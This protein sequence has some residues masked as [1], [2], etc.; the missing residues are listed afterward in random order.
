MIL[1][2]CCKI[3]IGLDILRRR[4]DGFHDLESVMVPV[5]GLYDVIE[6]TRIE[7]SGVEFSVEGIAVDCDADNNLCVKAFRLMQS[8]YS[9]GGVRIKLSKRIPFGAGLGGGSSDATTVLLGLNR[10]FDLGLSLGEIE[11]L[12]AELGSDTPFFARSMAQLCCGRG[13]IMSPV[14]LP[15]SGLWLLLV[16]PDINISTREAYSG[17]VPCEPATP[18]MARVSEP[19]EM[20]QGSVKNDFEKSLFLSHPELGDIKQKLLNCG[21]IYAAMSGSG[22][23]MFGLFKRRPEDIELFDGLF[24]HV[25]QF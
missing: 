19:V 11:S 20:W 14:E 21:A 17:V 12:A 15:L 4:S 24:T 25:E 1:N 3:N 2:A 13:E 23:T 22:S 7:G 16:K 18:L 8:R 6:L 5:R 9:I 10:L